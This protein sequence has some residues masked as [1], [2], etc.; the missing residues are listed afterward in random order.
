MKRLIL[1]ELILIFFATTFERDSPPG[2]FQ[3]TISLGN[4]IITDIQFLDS[5]NGWAV[6]DAGPS[7]D[8]AYVFK[9]SNGGVNWDFQYRFSAAFYKIQMI[10]YD[11]GYI[12]GT[13]GFGKM[14][15]TT[16]G[17]INW[18]I[19]SNFSASPMTDLHFVNV[20]TGW[21]C[22]DDILDGGVLKTTNGG[23]NWQ[24]QLG[25]SFRPDKIYFLNRDTGWVNSR[26]TV[27]SGLYKTVNGGINWNFID[28]IG[29][30]DIYF[31]SPLI[32]I[33][34]SGA[35]YKT[36][37]GGSN[38]YQA[39]GGLTGSKISFDSD[40]IG[41]AGYNLIYIPK[42]T[43]MGES[44]FLQTTNISN[45]SVS[46][47]D[48]L[49]AWAGGNGIVHTTD[50]GGPPVSITILSNEIPHEFLLYQNYPNP[51]NSM[52]KLKFQ[53]SKQKYVKIKIFDI[54][55]KAISY[56]VDK[57]LDAGTYETDWNAADFSSG[58]Y[59]YSLIIDGQLI[60][61]KKMILIK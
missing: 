7:F 15:K 12:A 31:F 4:K 26:G 48:S 25:V 60:A 40:S 56:L 11:T 42:T 59:F 8:T 50:G 6:T 54:T 29:M 16:N 53:V 57:K 58:I 17:G 49:L 20:N 19:V 37:D 21:I 61:T 30:S 39:T 44:W 10:D 52:T 41:W 14:W 3:Q 45:P 43:D 46:S 35:F 28:N 47:I 13:T 18:N 51:F 55:G 27:N 9:T 5:L 2:W 36:T 23:V 1:F 38:W 33:R 34:T 32:G 24:T 22:S